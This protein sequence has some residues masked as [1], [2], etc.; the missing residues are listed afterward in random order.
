M[1]A[2]SRA[3][4]SYKPIQLKLQSPVPKDIEVSRSVKGKE[5]DELAREISLT[6]KD[7]YPVGAYKAKVLCKPRDDFEKSDKKGN[8]I[9]VTGITPTSLGEGKSTTTMGLSQALVAHLKKN[10]IACIRQPSQGPTFGL[11]GGAAGGGYS[12]VWP[13]DEYNLHLTGDIHAITAANNLIVAAVD[14][15]IFHESTQNDE[16]LFKRLVSVP[17][18]RQAFN[19][20]QKK[21]LEKL[22][23]PTD[24]E[25]GALSPE[26]KKA[27]A[28][29]NIDPST[30][31]VNRV[32]DTNDRFLRKITIGQ[33][34]TEK[35]R[36]RETKFVISVASE[37]M[38]IVSLANDF[39]D[40]CRRVG[41]MVVA[42]SKQEAD[43]QPITCDDLCVSGAV[44]ALLKE[45]VYPTLIQTLEGSPVLVHC[46]PFANVAHGNSSIIADKI[47]LDLVGPDGYVVTEAGFASDIGFEKFM[48]IKCRNS[49]LMPD[50]AVLVATIRA[51]KL[52][53]RELLGQVA[54]DD[55]VALEKGLINMNAHIRNINE[56]FNVPVV[57]AINRFVTDQDEEIAFVKKM[58]LEA[59]A[60]DCQQANNWALGGQGALE[61]ANGIIETCAKRRREG[62]EP[63]LLYSD[64]ENL[65]IIE[66]IER[67][68]TQVYRAG[69]VDIP[70]EVRQRIQ[71]LEKA[72][73][74]HLPLC[75]AKTSMSISHDPKI[76]GA[77]SGYTFPIVDVNISAGAGF[78]YALAGEI[79]TMPGL[80]TRPAF[81]DITIEPETGCIDGLF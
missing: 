74:G 73:F 66:K 40:V 46:G 23:I 37:L 4:W 59:G 75:I 50:C 81:F 30:I 33:S 45:A 56:N 79:S 44:C 67:I 1:S 21:R 27:F 36:T 68:C 5:I 72:G 7:Y 3:A 12:Q 65:S 9:V 41:R 14:A 31:T 48:D 63:K 77:P 49:N 17:G 57:V 10:A 26:Q 18:G 70:D 20:F 34:P 58:A 47:A 80:P 19:S 38:A 71:V 24:M 35:N 13:M 15:R 42:F 51:L 55:D 52:H 53:G 43:P 2:T 11:K 69:K 60:A 16:D 54:V 32:I 22:A 28:R 39:A 62:K 76:K 29:L 25:P 6:K 78:L 61:L 64:D 8:Y